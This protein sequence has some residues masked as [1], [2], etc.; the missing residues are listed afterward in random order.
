[1]TNKQSQKNWPGTLSGRIYRLWR[2][3][4]A[5]AFLPF[6]NAWA[7]DN[8]PVGSVVVKPGSY[9]VDMGQATQTYANGLKPY[10]LVYD[11]IINR[12]VPVD[13][14]INPAKLFGGSDFTLGAK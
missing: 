12:K 1:M 9:V 3:I 14:V 5:L 8:G 2:V 10:G 4:A 7:I 6:G 13:W 11:L